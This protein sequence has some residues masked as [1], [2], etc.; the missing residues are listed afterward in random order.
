[1]YYTYAVYINYIIFA[2]SSSPKSAE[3]VDAA[4]HELDLDETAV[5]FQRTLS[6]VV[7]HEATRS[8]GDQAHLDGL[9]DQL[10]DQGQ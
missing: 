9:D 7:L 8:A 1:M 6:D 4:V 2:Y 3:V 10:E 5:V